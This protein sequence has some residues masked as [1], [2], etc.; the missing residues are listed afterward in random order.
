MTARVHY[1]SW[2]KDRRQSGTQARVPEQTHK[3]WVAAAEGSRSEKTRTEPDLQQ[4][5]AWEDSRQL[6]PLSRY[7]SL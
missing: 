3:L 4:A 7:K 1:Y 5:G 6:A 2:G